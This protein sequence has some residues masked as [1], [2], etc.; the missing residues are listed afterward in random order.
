VIGATR[1]AA[2]GFARLVSSIPIIVCSVFS[3]SCSSHH[4]T[5]AERPPA[6]IAYHAETMV[7][8]AGWSAVPEAGRSAS[9]QL[10][11]TKN[12][13]DAAMI[14]KELKPATSAKNMLTEEGVCVLGN[15]SMQSKLGTDSDERRIVQPPSVSGNGKEFCVYIYSE[16]SLLR[17]VVVFRA[18]SK[19]YEV[20]LRQNNE[21]LPLSSEAEAQ[22]A[23][24]NSLIR[25][26]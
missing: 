4:E 20:E 1:T 19:I 13:G 2:D 11:L 6:H 18:K 21:S 14:L 23:L 22:M 15:I 3:F 16:R 25:Q 5:A 7:I 8:P 12:D 24:V 26:D 17:R 9:P 10:I